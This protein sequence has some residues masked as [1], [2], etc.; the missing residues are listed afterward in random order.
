MLKK[1]NPLDFSEVSLKLRLLLMPPG[2][3]LFPVAPHLHSFH[4]LVLVKLLGHLSNLCH[5]K[6]VEELV[7]HIAV[8]EAQRKL[9]NFPKS[10]GLVLG[11]FIKTKWSCLDLWPE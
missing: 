10:V 11:T 6:G 5:V 4:L 3:L 7:P 9:N 1:D 8:T 2:C